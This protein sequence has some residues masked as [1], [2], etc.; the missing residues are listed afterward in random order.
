MADR[1]CRPDLILFNGRIITLDAQHPRA[2]A[3]AVHGNRIMAVGADG[4][5]I[6]LAGRTTQ[7]IN[8]D[9]KVAL[10][11]FVDAHI[12][13]MGTTEALHSV[14]LYDAT[15]RHD[16][17]RRV[18]EFARTVEPGQWILGYGWAQ[19]AWPDKQFPTRADLD[20]VIK[21][22]P[23]YL[24]ARSGH[25]AWVNSPALQRCGITAET[26]DPP[27]GQI[28]RDPDGEP[29][30]ILL[31]WSAMDLVARQIPPP[32]A[33][34]LARQM[35]RTQDTALALGITSIHD[36]DNQECL[37]ALQI[38]RERG[39]L[40]LRVLKQFNKPYLSSALAMGLRTGFGDDWIRIGALKIFADGA[41]GPHTAAML[42]PYDHEPDNVGIVVTDE[43]EMFDLISRATQVGIASTVHAIGD[44]AVRMVLN[45]FQRVRA[46]EAE[47]GIPRTQRRHR[48]EH[49]QLI[50]PEDVGRLAELDLIASMQPIHA[51][52]DYPVADR[53]WG[54][55]AA[56]SYN[57][58]LQLDRGVL[59]AFGSDS[60]YDM[61]G[62]IPAVHAAVTRRRADGSPGPVGWYP[63]ARVSLDEALHAHISAPA[64]CAGMEDRAGQLRPG[65][66]AD[67]VVLDR[68]WYAGPPDEI[69]GTQVLG[70]MVDGQWH[71][72]HFD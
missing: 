46:L 68:D 7:R 9:G 49:V 50:H 70:A 43:I 24:R 66:L 18:V 20:A 55:R 15:D 1:L 8:L 19:D 53:F 62:P 63:Q 36:F 28:V 47:L 56:F 52:S 48:I 40:H 3:I 22:H 57:P 60:P 35:L 54:A 13:W 58:R 26:P 72:R 17:A 44:R 25:A 11:G 69:L 30:G 38:L 2:T 14:Q 61:L 37:L 71:L 67:L 33:D 41:L 23:V 29:T 39:Q 27:D 32:S 12:H 31:E 5:I 64:Y 42:E 21:A 4:D 59:V 6:P 16:A 45:V 10:P 34:T 65:M 51:T